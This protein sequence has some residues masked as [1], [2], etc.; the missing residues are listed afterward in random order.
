MK[1][2]KYYKYILTLFLLII[3]TLT[4]CSQTDEEIEKASYLAGYQTFYS[5]EG[6]TIENLSINKTEKVRIDENISPEELKIYIIKAMKIS[7]ELAGIQEIMEKE[8]T[9]LSAMRWDLFKSGY[10]DAKFGNNPKWE[11][12]TEKK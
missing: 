3:M 2:S 1:Y 8:E 5:L 10:M 12:N 6:K 11:K 4:A 7:N 9:D